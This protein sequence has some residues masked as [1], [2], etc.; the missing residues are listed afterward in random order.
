MTMGG[1]R[2]NRF[3][4]WVLLLLAGPFFVNDLANIF[5]ESW[6][7]WLSIDYLFTKLLPG[8]I[9]IYLLRRKRLTFAEFGLVSHPLTAFL[10][11][12]V[13][14]VLVAVSVDQNA[15]TMIYTFPG[16]R[17]LGG[18][19]LIT[20]TFWQWFDL[21]IGLLLVGVVE[22]LVFRGYMHTVISR[23][24]RNPVAIV[25]ISAIFFGLIH[26]SLGL[27]AVLVTAVIGAFFMI[28]YLRSRSLPAVMLAHFLVNFID[29][30]GIVPK[31]LFKLI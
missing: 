23:Y 11:G 28:V 12:F 29:Y 14:A 10:V 21:T 30:A 5:V 16:Y 13:I 2:N 31:A 3:Y 25:T 15:Y 18:I 9:I 22:E 8:L 4:L 7:L 26:W 24:T 1:T 27:H 6:R 20:N 17:P 19:P